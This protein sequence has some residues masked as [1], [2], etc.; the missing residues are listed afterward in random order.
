M[1]Q[2]MVACE[3]QSL[4]SVICNCPVPRGEDNE[5]DT[6]GESKSLTESSLTVGRAQET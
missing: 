4:V 6:E 5:G 2:S 3:L 1:L